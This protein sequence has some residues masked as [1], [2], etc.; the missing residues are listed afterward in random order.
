MEILHRSVAASASDSYL[1][2]SRVGLFETHELVLLRESSN[3]IIESFSLLR[4]M[5]SASVVNL[6]SR[7]FYGSDSSSLCPLVLRAAL[8]GTPARGLPRRMRVSFVGCL[9]G[10]R[11]RGW[12][13]ASTKQRRREEGC[14][15][16]LVGIWKREDGT[17]KEER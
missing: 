8:F 5:S 16:R 1:L 9:S 3:S 2:G 7:L 14:A 13:V 11:V 12:R 15:G 17:K 6:S 10:W 4:P